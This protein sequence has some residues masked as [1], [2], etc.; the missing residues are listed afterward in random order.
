MADAVIRESDGLV[1][2]PVFRPMRTAPKAKA[3]CATPTVG[4]MTARRH[5]GPRGGPHA[6]HAEHGRRLGTDA[7]DDGVAD[8]QSIDDAALTTLKYLCS[9]RAGPAHQSRQPRGGVLLVPPLGPRMWPNC[10]PPPKEHARRALN[11]AAFQSTR[12]VRAS[13]AN[14]FA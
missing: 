12:A 8:P 4:F 9:R 5:V 14:V 3:G 2:P 1:Y 10:W 7:N 13:V 11:G 6:V